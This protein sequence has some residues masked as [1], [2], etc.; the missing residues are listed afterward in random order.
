MKITVIAGGLSHERDVSERSG[1]RVADALRDFGHEVTVSDTNPGLLR[2]LSA[3]RPDVV[4]PML[5]GAVGE[6]GTMREILK[7]L[8]LPYVGSTPSACRMSFDKSLAK[9]IVETAGVKVPFGIALPHTAYRELGADAV[10][11][12]VVQRVGLPAIV[13]PV[14]SGSSLGATV[15][16]DASEVPSALVSAFAYADVALVERFVEGTEV[17]VA[18]LDDGTGVRALPAVE[19][20]PDGGFYDYNARY[21]A[22]LTEFFCPARL[23]PAVAERAAEVAVTAHLALGLRDLS[24]ADLIIDADGEVWFL[25]TNVAPGFTET[26]LFP[27]AISAAGLQVGGVFDSLVS[28]AAQRGGHA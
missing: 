21:V 11:S 1:R 20:Q 15:V 18:V 27:Q 13:K 26:S 16:R 19:I 2:E 23:T 4:V 25:E 22:G 28:I 3:N 12:A 24:R 9:A 17:A 5:H 6:D 8:E 7:A 14:R 10:M